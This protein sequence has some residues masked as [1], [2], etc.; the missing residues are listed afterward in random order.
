MKTKLLLFIALM[1]FISYASLAQDTLAAWTFPTG[2]A[3]DANPD[4]HNT[5]N[6][7]VVISTGGGTSAIDWTKN[8]LTTK[9]AQTTGWDAGA[10]TKYWQIEVNTTNRNNLRLYS[11]QTAGGANAGPRDWK[12]QYKVGSAGSWTDIPATTLL[13]ANNWTS[14]VLANVSMPTACDNQASV[15]VRWLMISDTSVAPPALV[16][17][18]GTTKIDD[19]YVLG[20][21]ITSVDELQPTAFS[22]FPNPCHGSF[23]LTSAES[24][25]EINV[26][27]LMG[28]QVYHCKPDAQQH[29]INLTGIEKGI[30]FIRFSSK[31]SN[32]T[33][34]QKILI[35]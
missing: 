30:Y 6:A 26:Y 33:M 2:T 13:N 29:N 21:I 15:F 18:S 34:V 25:G 12:A 17:A 28:K 16:L 19:I 11:K 10:N 1:L 32:E 35:Q 22:V 20:S 8:G 24:L 3:T 4:V 31:A 23:T 14:A 9:A 7:A 5:N 27:N